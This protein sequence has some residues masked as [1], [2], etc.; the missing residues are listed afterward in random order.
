LNRK[1][2]ILTILGS[3]HDH[4]SNTRALVD[5]FVG[6]VA[7]AGLPLEHRLISLGRSKVLPCQGCWNCT[8][9]MPCP[10]S[11]KD[12]LEQIK[13]AMIECDIL[14]LACPVYCNQVTAQM[15]ALFDRL[16]TWCHIFP[17]LGTY[18]LTACTTGGDGLD[19]TSDFMQK[20]LATYGTYSLGTI[21]CRGGLTPGF[22]PGLSMARDRNRTL[23][24][25]VARMVLAGKLPR[26]NAMQ[27]KM[28]KVMKRKMI[29]IHTINC[30]NSGVEEGQ[31]RPPFLLRRMM[32][33]FV[34]K[35]GLSDR[36]LGKWARLLSFELGWWKERDWLRAG[37]FGD[38]LK[39][40]RHDGFDVR[41]HLLGGSPITGRK[42][43]VS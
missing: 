5:D 21:Q 22:F 42:E 38:L 37:S 26:V 17:L 9:S 32:G 28:F 25:G 36:D 6:Q 8:R 19:Q 41:Q 1:F 27:K 7:T 18:S 13:A 20:M 4:R 24:R 14:I 39:L 11:G 16:F 31:P 3:P 33:R 2:R 15:K 10:L 34:R 43:M 35:A 23:A 12:D 30:L 29:G 40:T